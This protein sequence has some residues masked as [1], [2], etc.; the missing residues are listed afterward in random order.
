MTMPW[1]DFLRA[2]FAALPAVYF[3]AAAIAHLRG[4]ATRGGVSERVESLCAEKGLR[5]L[6]AS[7]FV[8]VVRPLRKGTLWESAHLVEEAGGVV[9]ISVCGE[10]SSVV[11]EDGVWT[12]PANGTREAY[13]RPD[14]RDQAKAAAEDFSKALGGSVPVRAVV[15][16]RAESAA[17][18]AGGHAVP[19][20]TA[21]ECVEGAAAPGSDPFV[22]AAWD[23]FA[24]KWDEPSRAGTRARRTD[25]LKRAAAAAALAALWPGFWIAVLS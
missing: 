18:V 22:R 20:L 21:E 25:R 4:P 12:V 14:P 6:D 13:S 19:V 23:S 1:P 3:A 10:P 2:S 24:S 7:G 11:V 16:A 17:C 8:Q 5:R 15:A 9:L